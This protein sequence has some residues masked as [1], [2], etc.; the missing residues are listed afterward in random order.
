V[1]R[2]E[3]APPV[4]RS[5]EIRDRGEAALIAGGSLGGR[6][7]LIRLPLRTILLGGAMK[8]HP[9]VPRSLRGSLIRLP[10]RSPSGRL[11]PRAPS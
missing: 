7:S 4:P 6:G 5:L 3:A 2:D 8:L 1:G 10:L 9:P 11:A